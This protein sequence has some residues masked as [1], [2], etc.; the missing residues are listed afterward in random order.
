MTTPHQFRQ[1]LAGKIIAQKNN[2]A[3]LVALEGI[4]AAGKSTLCRELTDELRAEGQ[5]VISLSID[6]FHNKR[7]IRIRRGELSAEGYYLDSFDYDFV[8]NKILQPI[9]TATG[10]IEVPTRLFDYRNDVFLYREPA[11]V[12]AESIVLFEGVFLG[13]PEL[14]GFWDYRIYLDI[15]FET[16]FARGVKRDAWMGDRVRE[17]YLQRYMPG[18][19]IY[20]DQ[21]DPRESADLV[22]NGEIL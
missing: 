9:K 18:Q 20:L 8:I 4:D 1:N 21:C 7:E 16:S 10:D 2:R 3:L 14:R 5:S 17:K 6:S 15:S 19:R 12:S 22:I 13:R 11:T